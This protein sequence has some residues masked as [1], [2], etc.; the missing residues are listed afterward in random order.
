VSKPRTDKPL[1]FDGAAFLAAVD[2]IRQ[3]RGVKWFKVG[4]ATGVDDAVICRMRKGHQ[5]F[6]D[7]SAIT[8][9]S[10]AHWAGVDPMQFITQ[11]VEAK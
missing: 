2:T 6:A 5:S 4:R 11:R 7:S 8:I 9:L 10:L 1:Q 3:S